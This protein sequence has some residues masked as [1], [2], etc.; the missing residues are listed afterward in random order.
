MVLPW[1]YFHLLTSPPLPPLNPFPPP[2][3]LPHQPQVF[4]LILPSLHLLHHPL[5]YHPLLNHPLSLLYQ[6]LPHQ[7]HHLFGSVVSSSSFSGPFIK[8]R[9]LSISPHFCSGFM[10]V[11]QYGS[12]KINTCE[13]IETFVYVFLRE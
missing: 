7:S 9:N 4:V 13:N 3:H 12:A 10:F 2:F 1:F 6:S 5:S 11:Y 8:N